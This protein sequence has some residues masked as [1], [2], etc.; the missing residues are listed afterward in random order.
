MGVIYKARHVRLNRVVALKMILAGAHAGAEELRRFRVEA[1]AVAQLRHQNIVQIYEVGEHDG[2]PFLSLEYVEG[3]SLA[4]QLD[5]KP[6]PPMP[7]ARLVETLA[8]A[9]HFAHLQGIV[10]RDLKPANILLTGGSPSERSGSTQRASLGRQLSAA[11]VPALGVPKITDFGLAKRLDNAAS[12]HTA[13]GAVLGTPSYMAPEQAQGKNREIGPAAD[14]Y[15]LG[16]LLYE[17]LTG[18]PPFL[19]ANP[20]DT[21]LQV[22]TAEPVPPSRLQPKVPRDLETICL[23]CLQK[24]PRKRYLTAEDLAGDLGRYLDGKPILARPVGMLGQSWRWC[25]RNPVVASLLAALLLALAGG[26]TGVTALWLQT[27]AHLAEATYQ[28]ERAEENER[29]AD[30]QRRRAEEGYE[31]A[32]RA[33]EDYFTRVSEN[34]LLGLPNLEPLRKDLLES[35]LKFY[36]EMVAR[37]GNNPKMS[38]DLAVA[39]FRVATIT[40]LIGTKAK[41]HASYEEAVRQLGQLVAA[42]P[43]NVLMARRLGV[44]RNDYGL[45]LMESGGMP[46]AGKLFADARRDLEKLAEGHPADVEVRGALAKVYLN[47][48]LWHYKSGQTGE[49]FDFYE[50]CRK[51]QETI[52]RERPLMSEY[53]SDLALTLMNIGSLHLEQGAPDKALLLYQETLTIQQGLVKQHPDAIYYRRLLGAV[54]HNLGMLRRLASRPKEALTSYQESL[55]IRQR[56]AFEHPRVNDYQN[57][58]G[59]TLNNVGELQLANR[60]TRDALSTLEECLDVFTKLVAENPNNAKYRNALGLAHN[61]VGVVL[62]QLERSEEALKHHEEALKLRQE[63]YD[64]NPTVVDY[65]AHL[66]DTFSNLGNTRRVLKQTD[67]AVRSYETSAYHYEQ[68]IEANPGTTKY[69]TNLALAYTNLGY[70]EEERKNYP[71]ALEVFRKGLALRE[72]L[73]RRQPQGPPAPK[74]LAEAEAGPVVRGEMDVPRYEADVAQSHFYIGKVLARMDRPREAEAEYRQALAVQEELARIPDTFADFRADLG[75]TYIQMGNLIRDDKK[76]LDAFAW[77]KKARELW[78]QVVEEKPDVA[79]FQSNLAVSHYNFGITLQDLRLALAALAAHQAGLDLRAQLVK[80]HPRNVDY[81]RQLGESWNSVGIAQLS[82]RR[83]DDAFASFDKAR[84]IWAALVQE[85]PDKVRYRSDFGRAHLNLGITRF[86]QGKYEE[87]LPCFREA[88]AQ[89]LRTLE[90]K[91]NGR[92][93]RELL[94]KTYIHRAKSLQ[95]LNRLGEAAD[96]IESSLALLR[97]DQPAEAFKIAGWCE[98]LLGGENQAEVGLGALKEKPRFA[99]LAFRAYGHAGLSLAWRACVPGV[100]KIRNEHWD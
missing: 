10:H 89:H 3:G 19:A 30:D 59:E 54:H 55:K 69:R 26:F 86:E 62:H 13:S 85:Y 43:D 39:H 11:V 72:E 57:D 40:E 97:L 77:Y 70:L 42:N 25:R 83:R 8:Q 61:N 65:R 79:E 50:R 32:R 82:L 22:V 91:E 12:A 76:L 46:A 41:A 52:V 47:T 74:A 35:A 17:L 71:R 6:Q 90:M 95:Q 9:V 94:I 98:S 81:R 84:E 53:Q 28:R 31:H 33:V 80:D 96:A 75:R 18:R 2:L 87:S 44:C 63:L 64:V 99:R 14:I 27:R 100:S 23:K 51:L 68:L 60:L 5:G 58:H 92:R 20:V 15:A 21:M 37:A 78:K 7:A 36:Q 93:C 4:G 66:A 67:E 34:K 1:E 88:E 56:L 49:A 45:S 16:V 73:L 29:E 38:S 24:D 48:A